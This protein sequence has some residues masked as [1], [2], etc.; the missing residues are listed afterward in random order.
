MCNVAVFWDV[1]PCDATDKY[2]SLKDTTK[3]DS[4]TYHET[5]I[6]I[7]VHCHEI[8]ECHYP[9]YRFL[10]NETIKDLV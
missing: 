9:L 8:L 4:I 10:C 3:L 7:C 5:I 1:T 6:L 2:E